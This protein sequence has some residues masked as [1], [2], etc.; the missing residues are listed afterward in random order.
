MNNNNDLIT[1]PIGKILIIRKNGTKEFFK[2]KEDNTITELN[3]FERKYIDNIFNQPRDLFINYEM[4]AIEIARNNESLKGDYQFML[5]IIEAMDKVIPEKSKELFYK[6]LSTLQ[7]EITNREEKGSVPGNI[8][9]GRYSPIENKIEIH[10]EYLQYLQGLQEQNLIKSA[11]EKVLGT[12]TH[13]MFHMASSEYD[14]ESG[15][16]RIRIR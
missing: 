12:I 15:I 7:I 11:N 2:V 10:Q 3:E 4:S 1:L 5:P 9:A 14:K 8:S 16:V 6:N 13:E